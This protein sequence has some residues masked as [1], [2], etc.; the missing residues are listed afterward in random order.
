MKIYLSI[1]LSCFC[2]YLQPAYADDDED[3]LVQEEGVMFDHTR[4]G[5]FYKRTFYT[6]DE[7]VTYLPYYPTSYNDTSNQG[8]WKV[9]ISHWEQD[10]PS[11]VT[12]YIRDGSSNLNAKSEVDLQINIGA[13]DRLGNAI[14]ANRKRI[15]GIPIVPGINRIPLNIHNYKGDIVHIF[16]VDLRPKSAIGTIEGAQ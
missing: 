3:F 14:Y 1:F 11:F 8:H 16:M 4:T 12:V 9:Y 6:R 13:L 15:N 2:L 10:P 5:L 7:R